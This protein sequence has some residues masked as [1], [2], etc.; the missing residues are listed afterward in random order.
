MTAPWVSLHTHSWFFLME[1]VD[2]PDALLARAAEC[3]YAALALTDT[4]SLTGAVA[5]VEAAVR[6]GIRPLLGATL[7]YQKQQAVALCADVAGYHSLCR[8]LTAIHR[9]NGRTLAEVLVRHPQGLHL[10]VDDAA[11]LAR[12]LA[13]AFAGRLW[14]EVVRPQRTGAR[15]SALLEEASRLGLP[16]VAS[17][18]AFFTLPERYPACRFLAAVREGKRL[19]RLAPPPLGQAHHL[20]G[21]DDVLRRFRN[22]PGAL[23]NALRLADQC[24]AGPLPRQL[25]LPPLKAGDALDAHARLR[26]L[27]E[28]GLPRR[29]LQDQATA[30]RRLEEELAGIRGCGLSAYFVAVQEITS[31]AR[32]AGIPLALRGSAGG[33][34]VC[35]LLGIGDVDPLRYG[36][37]FERFLHPERR[38]APDIDLD[39]PA[40]ARHRVLTLTASR[41]GQERVAQVGT[42]MTRGPGTALADAALAHGLDGGQVKEL[43]RVLGKGLEPLLKAAGKEVPPAPEGFPLDE[44]KWPALVADA[45][46]LL[47]RPYT[48]APHPSGIVLTPEPTEGYIPLQPGSHG[49][50]LTQ[51][52]Q[53][54]VEAVGLIKIDIL[55]NRSLSVL[56]ETRELL[57]AQGEVFGTSLPEEADPVAVALLQASDTLG[58]AQLETPATRRLLAQARPDGVEELARCLAL[59][60]PGGAALG[61]RDAYLRRRRGVEPVRYPHPALEPVLQDNYGLLVFEDDALAVAVALAGCS[62]AARPT[63]CAAGCAVRARRR[64][65]PVCSA[66]PV[67]TPGCRTPWPTRCAARSPASRP[68]ASPGPTPSVTP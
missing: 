1:G 23:K 19:D 44:E 57:R 16:P 15:E 13:E 12:P 40:E 24:Q 65:A 11:L 51:L 18:S 48:L 7:H 14:A 39:F 35:Y 21:S 33:S 60:R 61:V 26:A 3:G 54:G 5:F 2:P 49:L 25:V 38:D 17:A 9:R 20:C 56:Q 43:K 45:R 30:R 66:R 42:L 47:G 53:D 10:L 41:F 50:S 64:R 8:V 4:N 63:T 31:D 55:S 22:C 52:N 59:L 36:L 29:P 58:I 6:H 67:A 62:P 46:L 32:R 68:T 27:C 28:A 37:P 34:L